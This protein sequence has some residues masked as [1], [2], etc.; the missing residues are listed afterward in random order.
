M[1]A[2]DGVAP[3][4]ELHDFVEAGRTPRRPAG[5][6]LLTGASQI[7]THHLPGCVSVRDAPMWLPVGIV[8]DAGQPRFRAEVD[9]TVGG[10]AVRGPRVDVACHASVISIDL[11][12][13]GASRAILGLAAERAAEGVAVV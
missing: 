12:V 13:E 5:S 1:D 7:A 9:P 4:V 11:R 3:H 2:T 10:V 8:V 6:R